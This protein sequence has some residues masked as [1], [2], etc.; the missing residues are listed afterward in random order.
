MAVKH[1]LVL[2][3]L[4]SGCSAVGLFPKKM[5]G[6]IRRGWSLLW[7]SPSGGQD[8]D[9]AES[10]VDIK[11][12]QNLLVCNGYTSIF[13]L[14]MYHRKYGELVT[15]SMPLYYKSCQEYLLPLV[16][17]DQLEFKKQ[18]K[19]VGT[20]HITGLK[21]GN[22]S[23]VLVPHRLKGSD[24]LT[25]ESHA[26]A[27]NSRPQIA[28]MDASRLNN[29]DSVQLSDLSTSQKATLDHVI[30]VDPGTYQLSLQ[31]N[32]TNSSLVLKDSDK[33]VAIRVG[34]DLPSGVS[35][36][37]HHTQFPA[38]LMV[39]VRPTYE[40]FL[41]AYSNARKQAVHYLILLFISAFMLTGEQ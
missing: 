15:S 19:Q 12:N 7:E 40:S 39:Y 22:M 18:D 27:E 26:F 10:M 33:T 21:H 11:Q 3:G 23:L 8:A 35:T 41:E 31:S 1:V 28:V 25:F 30:A 17:G 20:F 9:E 32:A 34:G 24:N 37:D 4:Y 13:P 14:D 6:A 5:R 16:D 2:C 38:E 36:E 29:G